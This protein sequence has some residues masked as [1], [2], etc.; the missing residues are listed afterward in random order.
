M[1]REDSKRQIMDATYRALCKH[2]YSD[3]S[4]QRIADEF[5][6]G[7]SLIYYHY[8][9]KQDLMNSFLDHMMERMEEEDM[10]KT[11]RSAEEQFDSL[12]D[13]T[14]AIEDEE[15]WEFR[16]A[17]MEIEAQTPHN[18][19]LAER[20]RKIDRVV[21]DKFEE[22]LAEMDIERPEAKAE[23]LISTID[24]IISRKMG[25]GTPKDLEKIKEDIKQTFT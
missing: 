20:F 1:G 15:M 8:N 2:G 22:V 5:E 4:I 16:K 23:L 10:L 25:H 18:K 3:L 7:K 6:K 9:D 19:E 13:K 24:G 11:S 17:L 14:L 21:K 12:L